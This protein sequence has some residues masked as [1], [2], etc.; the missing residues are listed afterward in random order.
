MHQQCK[1]FLRDLSLIDLSKRSDF[2]TTNSRCTSILFPPSIKS[3][4][5]HQSC[6]L[7]NRSFQK[8]LFSNAMKS[9]SDNVQGQ[10]L[11][12]SS[13]FVDHRDQELSSYHVSLT[14]IR[15]Q[16]NATE[17]SGMCNRTPMCDVPWVLVVEKKRE[18]HDG[19]SF[20]NRGSHRGRGV[21]GSSCGMGRAEVIVG[22]RL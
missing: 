21:A 22:F 9:C 2:F 19:E 7:R 5:N 13:T 17:I 12:P 10:D 20:A 14:N 8:Q 16:K 4:M 15:K 11:I 1:M 6:T 18:L 3:T